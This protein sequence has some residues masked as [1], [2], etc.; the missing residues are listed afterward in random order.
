[1]KALILILIFFAPVLQI[2]LCVLRYHSKIRLPI[3]IATILMFGLGYC[4]SY[5]A[6]YLENPLPLHPERLA[7]PTL[8]GVMIAGVLINIVGILVVDLFTSFA[9][10]SRWQEK[11]DWEKA[12]SLAKKIIYKL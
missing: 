9:Y 5:C 1:M 2:V 4:M 8:P 12:E 3:W 7:H 6:Q 11:R 10:L